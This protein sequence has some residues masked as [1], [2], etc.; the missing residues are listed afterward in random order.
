[1]HIKLLGTPRIIMQNPLSLHNYFAW[2]T[3]ARLRN[4]RIAVAASGFRLAHICPFGKTAMAISE[5]EGETYTAPAP[6]IDTVLDDRD[7]GLCPF[8]ERGLILTSFNNT[9]E[10]QRQRGQGGAYRDAYLDLVPAEAEQAAL[11]ATFRVS[12]DNGV[13]WGPL[14]R[15]PVTSP[16]G[17][18]EL[19]D[20]TILWVGRTFSNNDTFRHDQD[21]IMAYALDPADGSM[22]YRGRIDGIYDGDELLLSCEPHAIQLP[23]G[24]IICHIRVQRGGDQ[25][26]FTTYQ[27]ESADGGCTWSKPVQLLEARGGAPSHL[28]R[29]SS[30]VLLATY[31][32]RQLNYGIRAMLSADDGRTWETEHILYDTTVTA[33]LGYPATVE[34]HDGS[35]LTVF[36]AHPEK[37]QPAVIMQQKWCI[38]P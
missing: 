9:V 21:C 32:R 13:T 6:V 11:G 14:H 24:R 15:S 27:A 33:D 8:G 34:L 5:D 26:I 31:G 36:Y 1:M 23:D 20:G 25:P 16:H 19:H 30:G 10:F 12:L 22:T 37:G 29:H 18:T 35:L 3:A 17:P 28:L 4:G 7:A 2:P 38:E